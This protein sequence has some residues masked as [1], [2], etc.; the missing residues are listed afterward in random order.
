[1]VDTG[2]ERCVVPPYALG[3]VPGGPRSVPR[4]VEDGLGTRLAYRE[5]TLNGITG[6]A[7]SLLVRASIKLAGRELPGFYDVAVGGVLDYPIIGRR[8]LNQF[9]AL[10]DPP[11]QRLMLSN[12]VCMRGLAWCGGKFA[13]SG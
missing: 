2:A 8:V 9:V 11:G 4:F 7:P 5:T 1:M 6:A 13:K 10:L 3:I 12:C